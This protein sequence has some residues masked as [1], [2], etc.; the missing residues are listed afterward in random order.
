[1]VGTSTTTTFSYIPTV[2]WVVMVKETSIYSKDKKY[3]SKHK[4]LV[5]L[6]IRSNGPPPDLG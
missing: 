6:G 1:M 4:V 3:D 5:V 2:P